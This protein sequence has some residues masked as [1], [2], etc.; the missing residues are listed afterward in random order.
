[1]PDGRLPPRADLGYTAN[2]DG[3]EAD[4]AAPPGQDISQ[5][6]ASTGTAAP[7]EIPQPYNIYQKVIIASR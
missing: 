6:S 4:V 3:G 5:G 7:A 1:M 2:V